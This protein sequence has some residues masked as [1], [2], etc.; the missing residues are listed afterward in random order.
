MIGGIYCEIPLNRFYDKNVF[1]SVRWRLHKLI[2]GEVKFLNEQAFDYQILE[3]L[4]GIIRKH[5]RQRQKPQYEDR[6]EQLKNSY[7]YAV[8][9]LDKSKQA[10]LRQ[11]PSFANDMTGL[12]D[13]FVD[14]YEPLTQ[15]G[16]MVLLCV[17]APYAARVESNGEYEGDSE[18]KY[19]YKGFDKK[20]LMNMVTTLSQRIR[21]DAGRKGVD[22]HYGYILNSKRY[23]TVGQRLPLE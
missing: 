9:D 23:N 15:T 19:K 2:G 13:E 14:T 6:T 17:T 16:W 1:Y 20:V 21:E 10:L 22:L 12:F 5:F 18:G 8:Y 11:Q 4:N 7:G 3:T